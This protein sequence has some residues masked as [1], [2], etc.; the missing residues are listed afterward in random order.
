MGMIKVYHT[1]PPSLM[2]NEEIIRWTYD[3]MNT[4]YN[5]LMSFYYMKMYSKFFEV[6]KKIKQEEKNV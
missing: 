2:R 3:Q 4:N 5:P 1:I 6:L